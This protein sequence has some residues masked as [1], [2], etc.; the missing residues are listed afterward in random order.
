MPEVV[1]TEDYLIIRLTAS[2]CILDYK[3]ITEYGL[4]Q[5]FLQDEHTL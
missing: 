4:H 2:K 5:S 3:P 1:L